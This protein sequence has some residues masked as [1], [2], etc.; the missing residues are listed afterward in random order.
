[1]KL[2]RNDLCWCNNG[3]KYKK[4]HMDFDAKIQSYANMGIIVPDRSLIKSK[5]QIDGIRE[6]GLINN[7]ILDEVGKNIKIG[8]STD[9]INTLVHELTISKGAI[10]APL[11]YEGFPKSAC[12]SINDVV[13][14]GIPSKN[15]ILKSGDIINVDVTTIYNGYFAD[16]SRMYCIGQ[17]MPEAKQLVEVTKSALEAGI[18]AIKPWGNL[19][20]IAAAICETAYKYGYSVIEEIGGHGIGICFHEDPY[21]CHVG[22]KGEGMLLVPGMVFTVEPMINAGKEEFYTDEENGWTIYTKDGSLSA[23]WEYTLVVTETGIELLAW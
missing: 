16:A 8:M 11:G 21:V 9:E 13:C 5:E 15:D 14:H 19:G 17:V 23:Q 12:T 22:E 20:D 10:P 18:A 7:W 1:M 2:D 3:K 6:S 4:C